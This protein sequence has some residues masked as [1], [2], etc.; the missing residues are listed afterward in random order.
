MIKSVYLIQSYE[1]VPFLMFLISLRKSHEKIK[2]LNY[3]NSDLKLHL[4]K[5]FK[6]DDITLINNTLENKKNFKSKMIY[7]VMRL[8]YVFKHYWILLTLVKKSEKL[9]FFTPFVVPLISS[10]GLNGLSKICYQPLPGLI[11]RKYITESGEYTMNSYINTKENKF[12]KLLRRV[13][14]G[15]NLEQRF[16]GSTKIY[17]IT[18]NLLSKIIK[19]NNKLDFSMQDY[20]KYRTDIYPSLIK[21]TNKKNNKI[22]VIYFEQHYVERKLVDEFKYLGLLKDIIRLCTLEELDFYVKPHPGRALP[23]F[24]EKFDKVN[25]IEAQTPAEFYIDEDTICI[26][27]SSGALS[28]SLCKLNLSLI[29]LMPFFDDIFRKNAFKSL[30]HKISKLT[31]TPKKINELEVLLSNVKKLNPMEK[32][33]DFIK[34]Q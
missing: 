33:I 25:T 15:R 3:G 27:T 2:V 30:G 10:I 26:S 4:L 34:P 7:T 19:N 11:K 23:K 24:Y 8:Q 12:S 14:F 20:E 18:V 16:I 29:F 1:E 5:V 21:V 22:R 31:F 6:K 9:Y 32:D 13:L 17:A 28:S